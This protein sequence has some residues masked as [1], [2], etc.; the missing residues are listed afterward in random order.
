M[1]SDIP[2]KVILR[3]LEPEDIDLLY[4][5]ENNSEIWH[6]S[7]TITPFSRYILK[8]YIESSHQDIYQTRQLRLMIDVNENGVNKTVGAID[9]FDFEPQHLRVG[10]GVLI[11]DYEERGKGYA[12][13]ALKALLEYVFNVLQLNQVYCNILTSNT[14][15][16]NLFKKHGFEVIGTKKKWIKTSDGFAD[17]EILQ[18]LN[19]NL[20]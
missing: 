9:L 8:K 12:D 10:I 13:K 3:A 20:Q 1:T 15:S 11:G 14:I 4:Q 17:E 18:L 7:N 16:L 6:L 19:P 2:N 5:W